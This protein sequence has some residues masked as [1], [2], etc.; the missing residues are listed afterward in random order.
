MNFNY[1]FFVK[2]VFLKIGYY[3][4]IFILIKILFYC[5]VLFILIVLF[6]GVLVDIWY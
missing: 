4:D 6:Y 5:I 2:N 3:V 1:V